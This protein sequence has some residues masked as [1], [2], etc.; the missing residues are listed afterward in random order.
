MQAIGI[1]PQLADPFPHRY[2]LNVQLLISG[3]PRDGNSAI[4]DQG[5]HSFGSLVFDENHMAFLNEVVSDEDIAKYNLPFKPGAGRYWT[6]DRERDCYLWGGIIENFARDYVP[7]GRFWFYFHQIC[8][9]VSLSV[10]I[11]PSSSGKDSFQVLWDEVAHI[12]PWN[13][14][15]LDEREFLSVLKDALLVFGRDG[16][17]DL[18][19]E[20]LAVKFNF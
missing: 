11:F 3:T 8:F 4:A 6:R 19:T 16:E 13:Q 7:E 20:R 9:D 18:P 1:L 12:Q 5:F 10:A 17:N 14:V 2:L 15:G